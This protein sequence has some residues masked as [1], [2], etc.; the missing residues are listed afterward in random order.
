[1]PVPDRAW[2]F[3][4]RIVPFMPPSLTYT[5][6]RVET[7]TLSQVAAGLA[8]TDLSRPSPC[9]PWTVADL[10]GHVIIASGRIEQA[11]EA[12][13]GAPGELVSARGYYRADERFSADVNADRIDVAVAL[14]ARLRTAAAIA[15]QLTAAG[16]RSLALLEAAPAGQVV[17]TRHGDRMLLPEF[18]ITRVVE[19]GLHG[20][21]LAAALGREAWLTPAAAGVLENL[22]LPAGAPSPREL[23]DRLN[24]DRAGVIARLTGR[25][26]LSAGDRDQ[27]AQLGVTELALG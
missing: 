6:L 1:M 12:G 19:L 24:C 5:A 26:P 16:D 13:P 20:L 10:L 18:A 21:D 14:A 9:P 15:A 23:A 25:V 17:R 8:G 2:R 22:L 3:G 27:L 7:A 4:C 11:I